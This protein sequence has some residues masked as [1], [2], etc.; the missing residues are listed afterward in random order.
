MKKKNILNRAMFRQVKSPAYGTGI[1]S[2]LVS[3]EER[4]RYNYGGRVGLETGTDVGFQ[5]SPFMKQMRSIGEP[6]YNYGVRPLYNLARH[7]ANWL[8]EAFGYG[9]TA[10]F[11]H[12][13][14]IDITEEGEQFYPFTTKKSQPEKKIEGWQDRERPGGEHK[15]FGDPYDVV[16]KESDVLDIRVGD[17]GP[18]TMRGEGKTAIEKELDPG[19]G[20]KVEPKEDPIVKM[21]EENEKRAKK[22]G[23]LAAITQGVSMASN[24]LTEPTFA[25]AIAKAGKESPKLAKAYSDEVTK[26][27][28]LPLQWDMIKEKI[29]LEGKEKIELEKEKAKSDAWKEDYYPALLALR[30]Q[31]MDITGDPPAI[32]D[33]LRLTTLKSSSPSDAAVALS[34]SLSYR[35]IPIGTIEVVNISELR[36][37][38]EKTKSHQGKLVK[39]SAKGGLWYIVSGDGKI[40]KGLTD[41]DVAEMDFSSLVEK[42]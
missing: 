39:D 25:K 36:K 9:E 6:L 22:R 7:P 20:L 37:S 31:Q 16:E 12:Q 14:A 5:Q 30:K 42:N 27:E 28:D 32:L 29:K 13:E 35:G 33:E 38:P 40:S 11:P 2:N 34:D 26:A 17:E 1:A 8:G 4:Q 23:K 41:K 18:W 21:L 10:D 24:L 3:S 19:A 15:L